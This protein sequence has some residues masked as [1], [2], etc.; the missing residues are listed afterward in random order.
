MV[1]DFEANHLSADAIKVQINE[2]VEHTLQVCA[3]R[4]CLRGSV[5][6][7]DVLACVSPNLQLTAI[8]SSVPIARSPLPP[9]I[10]ANTLF[11]TDSMPSKMLREYSMIVGVEFL[12]RLLR[13]AI[14]ALAEVDHELAD[15]RRRPV[16]C[17]VGR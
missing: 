7:R 10:Q 16:R 9:P 8:S 15:P 2:E 1:C 13:P 3:G 17:C 5:D 14:D 12:Y 6:S 11:R 4:A